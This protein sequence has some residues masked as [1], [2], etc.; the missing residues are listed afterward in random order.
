MKERNGRG[1]GVILKRVSDGCGR[2]EERQKYLEKNREKKHSA[3]ANH[4]DV[5][6]DSDGV[7]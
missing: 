6:F 4:N 7:K 2:D 1:G 3:P 5:C